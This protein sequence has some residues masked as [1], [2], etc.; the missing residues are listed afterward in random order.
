MQ[1]CFLLYSSSDTALLLD[2]QPIVAPFAGAP[3]AFDPMSRVNAPSKIGKDKAII[4]Q[5]GR[6]SSLQLVPVHK[7]LKAT[8]KACGL[9]MLASA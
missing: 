6:I 7:S 2:L 4:Q 3:D 8:G 5:T 9:L 1:I